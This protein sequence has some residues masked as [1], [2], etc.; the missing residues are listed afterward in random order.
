MKKLALFFLTVIF[1]ACSNNPVPKPEIL[2]ADETMENILFD[3]TI[4]QAAESTVS[5]KLAENNLKV[6]TF[7]YKKYKIDSLTYHQNQK[8]YAAN[9]KK[10]KKMYK[11]VL[12]RIDKAQIET[13]P[14]PIATGNRKLEV[15]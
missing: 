13:Q 4:L 7:I 6:T 3:V 11:R 8:Y 14:K 15:K 12:E 5:Y 2:L 10:Y 1:F 9:P